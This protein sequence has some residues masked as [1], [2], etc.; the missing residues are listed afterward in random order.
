MKKKID[1]LLD[2]RNAIA[3]GQRHFVAKYDAENYYDTFL[4]IIELYKEKLFE[5]ANGK[6]YLA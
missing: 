4:I 5:L 6:K 1:G 2:V 3:H